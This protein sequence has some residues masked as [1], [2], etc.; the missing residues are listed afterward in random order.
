MGLGY[1]GLNYLILSCCNFFIF[2]I[3]MLNKYGGFWNA[4]CKFQKLTSHQK[5]QNQNKRNSISKCTKRS[6][7]IQTNR[8]R[9]PNP[10]AGTTTKC[11]RVEAIPFFN[12]FTHLYL[13][14]KYIIAEFLC[15]FIS[16][17]SAPT[18]FCNT[19]QYWCTD[20]ANQKKSIF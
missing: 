5:H 4:I 6:N 9:M 10:N 20:N 18:Q 13:F 11:N 2:K 14:I 8:N 17:K 7:Q 15:H 1:Q 19:S 16:D 12:A 3:T